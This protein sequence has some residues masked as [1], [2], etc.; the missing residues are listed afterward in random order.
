[1][2]ASY[3]FSHYPSQGMNRRIEMGAAYTKIQ[4]GTGRHIDTDGLAHIKHI[5]RHVYTHTH[6]HIYIYIYIYTRGTHKNVQLINSTFIVYCRCAII[7]LLDII[8]LIILIFLHIFE[9][10]CIYLVIYLS[11]LCKCSLPKIKR[12]ERKRE[13]KEEYPIFRRFSICVCVCVCVWIHI[14]IYIYIYKYIYIWL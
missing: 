13:R 7:S 12:R 3:I 2:I 4:T 10:L 11:R 5:Q 6:T 8:K 1:M 14:Y 9:W